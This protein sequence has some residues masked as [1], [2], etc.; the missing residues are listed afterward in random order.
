MPLPEKT[1]TAV[2][3]AA[4]HVESKEDVEPAGV[5]NPAVNTEETDKGE[6]GKYNAPNEI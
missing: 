5:D 3:M 1:D 6:E 2:E 4:Q